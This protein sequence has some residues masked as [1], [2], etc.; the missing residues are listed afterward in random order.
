MPPPPGLRLNKRRLLLFPCSNHT[1]HSAAGMTGVDYYLQVP[2]PRVRSI[3]ASAFTGLGSL[4]VTD[5]AD[6]GLASKDNAAG[7][8]APPA[9]RFKAAHAP[10]S[11]SALSSVHLREQHI[12]QG[13]V[14]PTA[15]GSLLSSNPLSRE[16]PPS[17]HTSLIGEDLLVSAPHPGCTLGMSMPLD[18]FPGDAE[19]YSVSLSFSR[20]DGG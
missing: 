17:G 2:A 5:V 20:S 19:Y 14:T 6:V 3:S 8:D 12:C 16:C 1:T 4:T 18:E 7:R 11:Q 10:A 15:N 9:V 13:G